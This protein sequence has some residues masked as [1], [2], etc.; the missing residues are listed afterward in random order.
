MGEDS[1]RAGENGERAERIESKY[2]ARVEGRS[3]DEQK[4]CK[5]KSQCKPT[6]PPTD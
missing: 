5:H 6:G 4:G 3:E 1:C 2:R